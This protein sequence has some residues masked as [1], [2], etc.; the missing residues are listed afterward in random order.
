MITKKKIATLKPRVQLR[1][2]GAIF[3]EMNLYDPEYLDDIFSYLLTLPSLSDEDRE[4]LSFFYSSKSSVSGD[5]I[6]YYL[7]SKLGESPADWDAKDQEGEIDWSRRIV[8]EHYLYLDHLRS[9]YNVG[10]VF[11]SAESFCVRKIFISPGTASPMH[12]R[13]VRTSRNTVYGLPWEEALIDELDMPV[14]ALELGGVDIDSFSFPE[15]G[16]CIIGNEESGVS[17]EAL[18]AADRSLGRVSIP[19]YGAKG[20]INVS[21]AA[22]ILLYEWTKRGNLL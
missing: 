20:S 22:S 14:F 5:D 8:R 7:L 16:I 18:A 2:I 1:K 15:K 6:Y 21:S 10:S 11:R 9:P 13:A 17:P 3:H 19:Q 4:R 12:D